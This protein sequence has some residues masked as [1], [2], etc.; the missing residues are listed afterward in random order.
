[1]AFL[2]IIKDDGVP[3]EELVLKYK[4]GADQQV[5]AVVFQ[6]YM[7]LLYGVCLKYLSDPEEAQ[8]AVMQIY[9]EI[10]VKLLQHDVQHF[11]NWLYTVAKN[12]CLMK[13]RSSKNLKTI[14]LT[15]ETMQFD[16]EL[17]LNG[18]LEKEENFIKMDKC[19]KTLD[20]QQRQAVELFYLQGSCYKQIAQAT[21]LDWN[22]VRSF[23][24]NG[25]RNLKICMEKRI[26]NSG[27]PAIDK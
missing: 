1:M 20:P 13:L 18:M 8:D 17:H 22:R 19:L 15:E 3:D 9:Q 16:E 7:E 5:L 11:K 23:I 24:Q 25:R 26:S 2:K 14:N 6:R 21:G 4:S 12:H 27:A 10:T